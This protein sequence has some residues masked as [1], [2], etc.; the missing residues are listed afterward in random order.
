MLL[1]DKTKGLGFDSFR[2]ISLCNSWKGIL[3]SDS[4]LAKLFK[5]YFHIF[6]IN[7]DI[8][9]MLLSEINKGLGSIPL[10]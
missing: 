9:E 5:K 6:F 2:I 4:Y 7:V 1:L 3:V 8:D 10:L